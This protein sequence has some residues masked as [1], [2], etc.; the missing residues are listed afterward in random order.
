MSVIPQEKDEAYDR[1]C[2]N[3]RKLWENGLR[4]PEAFPGHCDD[5]SQVS[6][7]TAIA[8]EAF[9]NR[10][11]I[12]KLAIATLEFYGAAGDKD[13]RLKHTIV[14]IAHRFSEVLRDSEVSADWLSP[15]PFIRHLAEVCGFKE[16]DT[17]GPTPR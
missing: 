14:D 9:S 7:I 11:H 13:L 16:L 3:T 5:E 17:Q 4:W 10:R 2:E 1:I 12:T 8:E 6:P 15:I